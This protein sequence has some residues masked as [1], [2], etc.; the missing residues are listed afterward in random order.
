MKESAGIS[1][2]DLLKIGGLAAAG[3]M[4][5]AALAGC[6]SPKDANSKQAQTAAS[7]WRDKP[8]AITNISDTVDCD[9]VVVGAGNGGLPAAMT[10]QQKGFNV[11]VLEKGGAIAMAREAVGALNSRYSVGHEVDVP[12]LI[13]WAQHV[14]S[15][16]VSM[17]L[18]RAW[19][20][21]SGEYLNWLGDLEEPEGMTFPFE[22]HAPDPAIAPEAYYPPMCHNPVMGQFNPSGPN[23]GAYT[24][25][26]VLADLFA[27]AGGQIEFSAP[28]KQLVQNGDGSVTGAIAQKADGSYVQYNA[29]KGVILC[30]GGYGANK[31]MLADLCPSS[32]NYCT[33]TSATTEEGDG[34]R[35]ALWA[36]AVLE[37]GGGSMVWNRGVVTDD[38]E[39]GPDLANPLFLPG[40]Q[41]FL[42]VNVRGERYMNEDQCYP[43]SYAMG[44]RQPKGFGWEVFDGT[45][46]EDIQRFDT[47]GCSRLVTAPNGSAFNADV[48]DL[49]PMSK[50][51]L[52]SFW[53]AP[54]LEAGILKKC[55]TLQQL[56]DAMFE[57]ADDKKTFLATVDRYNKV[58]ASGTDT[59][60]GKE[61]YRCSTLDTPPFYAI[62]MA[63][64]FLVTI[65]GVITDENSQPLR[66]DGSTIEGLYVCGNDQGGFYPHS[67][68]SNFTGINCGRCGTFGRI[69]AKHA[70]GIA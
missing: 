61:A 12:K 54:V 51:H 19:A 23:L 9:L 1:R 6:S 29:K 13:N 14:E 43:M 16:D 52:D 5:A 27:K 58:M 50:E 22:Y 10:A 67:Y 57:S 34:I 17:P 24:H 53:M 37:E 56:A 63:G 55:D 40:S 68:P 70:C 20:E 44:T 8:Q 47:G 38:E 49:Q 69:A 4:G 26:Q 66:K 42:H 11:V 45:Y 32:I 60:F 48:Y 28:A 39:V 25:L 30:T 35:M 2:R 46:W 59:D 3:A 18:Y 62:R 64:N 33:S 15:G 31:E 7:S 21:R 36:G 65:H 41:P